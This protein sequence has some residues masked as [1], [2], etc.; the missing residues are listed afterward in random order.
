MVSTLSRV[1]LCAA[2]VLFGVPSWSQPHAS[3]TVS[4]AIASVAPHTAPRR[5]RYIVLHHTATA[6]G[7]VASIE[8]AHL[9]RGMNR[10]LAYHFLIGNG[11]GLGDGAVEPGVRWRRQLPG[12]HVASALC[13]PERGVPYD[14][15][16]I[17]IALVGDL[18]Q[19]PPTA[20]QQRAL[21]E[22]V[23][24][25]QRRFHI[26]AAHV[27]G[28]GEVLGAHTACPGR[29]LGGGRAWATGAARRAELRRAVLRRAV[30]RARR[31]RR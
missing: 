26:D 3:G 9:R 24:S 10:G 15:V 25:L 20:A 22:L 12:A 8:S 27:M 14:E 28:H 13:E 16:A 17:G 11:R 18:E 30:L 29:R 1:V 4:H 21:R 2:M 7:T 5:W 19:R 6:G 31:R 23:A